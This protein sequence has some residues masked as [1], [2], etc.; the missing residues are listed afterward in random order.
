MTLPANKKP[1]K[2]AQ[3]F[4][5]TWGIALLVAI[6]V[7]LSLFLLLPQLLHSSPAKPVLDTVIPQI[8]MV[9]LKRPDRPNSTVERKKAPPPQNMQ[10][11]QPK[12]ALM[13]RSQLQRP[14]WPFELNDRLPSVPGS[15]ALPPIETNLGK[16]LALNDLF[17]VG[18]LDRPLITLS[19]MPPIYPLAAKRKGVEGW[20]AVRFIVNKQGRVEEITIV[21]AQPPGLFET[22][23]RRC[24]SAWRFKPGTIDGEAVRVWAKTTFRFELE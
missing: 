5:E 13:Q 9:R 7:N 21:E 22:S 11:R 8:Q 6:A 24:V 4:W 16:S 15:P 1:L 17:G 18:D 12:P 14:R 19:R 2:F 20:V 10:I 3:T 23:I